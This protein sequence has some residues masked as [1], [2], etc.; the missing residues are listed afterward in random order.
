MILDKNGCQSFKYIDHWQT[1][2][3]CI[4]INGV[5]Y[6]PVTDDNPKLKYFCSR[7]SG[8]KSG[9]YRDNDF[10]YLTE[11]QVLDFGGVPLS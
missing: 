3:H 2:H 10:I 9:S 7:P 5:V 6:I 1:Y 11:K 4:T 8:S